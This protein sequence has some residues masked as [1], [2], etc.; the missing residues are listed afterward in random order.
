MVVVEV[1][2]M[3]EKARVGR[4]H[5]IRRQRRGEAVSLVVHT[6]LVERHKLVVVMPVVMSVAVVGRRVENVMT[7][8]RAA[9]DWLLLRLLHPII[10]SLWPSL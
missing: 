2:R 5:A 10:T 9:S 3:G 1:R 7:T 4:P 8:A 6:P